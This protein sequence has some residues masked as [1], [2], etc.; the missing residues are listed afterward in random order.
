MTQ[1]RLT[2][3]DVTSNDVVSNDALLTHLRKLKLELKF[4]TLTSEEKEL[5]AAAKLIMR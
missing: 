4:Q 1:R 3:K 2:W 5:I